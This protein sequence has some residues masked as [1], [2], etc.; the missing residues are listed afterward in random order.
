MN[1]REGNK[2]VSLPEEHETDPQRMRL[3]VQIACPTPRGMMDHGVN[4]SP[5]LASFYLRAFPPEQW[6]LWAL[7]SPPCAFVGVTVTGIARNLHPIP[8]ALPLRSVAHRCADTP[9]I[10]LSPSL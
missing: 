1:Q 10:H 7:C 2:K 6:L 3:P 9:A 4:K 8:M 5:G